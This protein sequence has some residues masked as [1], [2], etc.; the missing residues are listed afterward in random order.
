MTS[1]HPSETTEEKLWDPHDGLKDQ[2]AIV[3]GGGRGLGEWIALGLAQ[4][5]ADVVVAARTLSECK[6]VAKRIRAAGRRSLAVRADVTK[7][8]YCEKLVNTALDEFGR[9]DILVNNAGGG[10][11]KSTLEFSEADFDQIVAVNFKAVFFC[12]QAAARAMIHYGGGRIVNI[13]STAG[14]L[15]RPATPPQAAYSAAK[16]AVSSLT[17]ALAYEWAGKGIRVNCVAPGF[18]A[19]PAT[20][21]IRSSPEWV[22]EFMKTTPLERVGEGPDIVGAVLFLASEQSCFITGQ[23]IFADGGRSIL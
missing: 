22:A 6:Q 12:S 23:T 3:T 10:K 18:F 17:R 15:I 14:H 20:S 16:A 2:V 13:G 21:F 7:P 5:G 8:A 19:T 9:L 4:A 1:K 11:A